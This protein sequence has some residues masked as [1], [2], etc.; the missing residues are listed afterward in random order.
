MMYCLCIKIKEDIL[1]LF[2]SYHD[3][4]KFIVDYDDENGINFLDIKL[5]KKEGK[6]IF[7]I[8][9]KPTNSREIF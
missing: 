7:D 9:K 3:R 5:M 6:I 8:Y 4:I 1:E 2:N